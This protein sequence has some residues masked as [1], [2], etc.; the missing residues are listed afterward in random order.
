MKSNLK[1][2]F[3]DKQIKRF[4]FINGM[5]FVIFII[6]FI[7]KWSSLPSQI[8]IFYSLPRSNDQL[9]TPIKIS[10]LPIFA[11]IFSLINYYL[12]FILYTKERLAAVI[13]TVMAT[14]ATLLLFFTFVKIIFLIT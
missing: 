10:T 13:L 5:I 3:N 2:F 7:F 8:P 4:S 1:E 12:A 14:T 6:L 11:F 9:G